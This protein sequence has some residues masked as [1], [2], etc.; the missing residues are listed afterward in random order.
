MAETSA[1]EA[2]RRTTRRARNVRSGDLVVLTLVGGLLLLFFNYDFYDIIGFLY[3]PWVGLVILLLILEF[4]WLK[5]TDRTR[6]YRL[7]LDRLRD[8][9]RHDERLLRRAREVLDRGIRG[10]ATEE[11]GRPGDWQRHAKDLLDDMEERL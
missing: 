9:A 6:V 11:E 8:R 5:S 2:G 4:L 7:E 3:N 10:P 1:Q